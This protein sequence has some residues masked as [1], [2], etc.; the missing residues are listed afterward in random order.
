MK[1]KHLSFAFVEGE[2]VTAVRRGDWLLLDE[3]N[4]APAELLESISGLLDSGAL[5]VPDIAGGPIPK[6]KNF[7]IFGS[8]NPANDY[9]KKDLPDSLRNRFTE[10]YVEE[11]NNENDIGNIVTHYLPSLR[12]TGDTATGIGYTL[13][14]PVYFASKKSKQNS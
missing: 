3:I 13:S 4:L 1:R 6:H 10:L 9:A 14:L 12:L 8:M 7:R 11:A 2:L 5:S